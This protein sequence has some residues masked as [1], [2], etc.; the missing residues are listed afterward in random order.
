MNFHEQQSKLILIGTVVK[1]PV[2]MEFILCCREI[3]QQ[4]T[5]RESHLERGIGK[6]NVAWLL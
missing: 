5:G 4:K 2:L 3:S 6:T 1:A